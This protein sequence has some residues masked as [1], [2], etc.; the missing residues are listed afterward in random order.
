MLSHSS[1]QRRVDSRME[2]FHYSHVD[3]QA[4]PADLLDVVLPEDFY[5]FNYISEDDEEEEQTADNLENDKN[6]IGIVSTV[7]KVIA[8]PF[9]FM[10]YVLEML[11]EGFYKKT[12]Y[13]KY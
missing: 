2:S 6:N 10:F 9:N 11:I 3:P 1:P 7:S 4:I 13:E 12:N 5:R 8:S